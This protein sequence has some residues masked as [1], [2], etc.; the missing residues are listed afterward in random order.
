[1]FRINRR[2]TEKGET[3]NHAAVHAGKEAIQPMGVVPSFADHH[4]IASQD[5][6]G[7]WVLQVLAEKHP[8]QLRPG[9]DGAKEALHRTIATT[10]AG[11]TRDAKHGDPP[12]HRQQRHDDLAEMAQ[13]RGRYEWLEAL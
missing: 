10:W 13:R 12:G 8:K 4:L 1:M 7:V 6:N 9:Q 2:E 5:I 11:P 3:R